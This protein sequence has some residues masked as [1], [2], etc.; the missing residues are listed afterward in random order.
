MAAG[1]KGHH[2]LLEDLILADDHLARLG[3]HLCVYFW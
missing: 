3:L 2:H 1:E